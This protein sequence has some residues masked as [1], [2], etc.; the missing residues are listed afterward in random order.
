MRA[1]ASARPSLL[2]R[3]LACLVSAAM[4][5]AFTPVVAWGAEPPIKGSSTI[6]YY[7]LTTYENTTK[8]ASEMLV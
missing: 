3:A 4:C 8:I 7:C 5:V 2:K 1:R 6:E